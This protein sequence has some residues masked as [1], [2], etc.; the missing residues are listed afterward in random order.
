MLFNIKQ[1]AISFSALAISFALAGCDG[2]DGKGDDGNAESKKKSAGIPPK[3]SNNQKPAETSLAT[4]LK[5]KKIVVKDSDSPQR[6]MFVFEE[7][8]G[9]PMFAMA[10]ETPKGFR[11]RDFPQGAYE[12]DG[13]EVEMPDG[14]YL[15]FS[16][17]TP[18]AGDTI[19]VRESADADVPE[20]SDPSD[21]SEPSEPSEPGE[22]SEP[23]DKVDA[24]EPK[25]VATFIIDK[26]IGADESVKIIEP[27]KSQADQNRM[28]KS[29]HG[30]RQIGI[31]FQPGDLNP[32][33]E[34]P[35]AWGDVFL[36]EMGGQR[37][38]KFFLSPRLPGYEKLRAQLEAQLKAGN[39]IKKENRI[40]HYAINKSMIGKS[41]F[42]VEGKADSTVLMFECE[43]GW[44]GAGGLEDALKFMDKHQLKAIAVVMVRGDG[45][46]V[47][48]EELKKLTWKVGP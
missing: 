38:L 19:K 25:I 31:A 48:R 46:P 15:V 4:F 27:D 1:F 45:K 13:L 5:G 34:F 10:L 24:Q 17:K 43:L 40:C 16:S 42:D 11:K 18:K 28:L 36:K 3:A 7:I 21:P 29:I 33:G 37:G 26:I 6:A 9:L 30:L 22:P 39:E 20:P 32:N 44:N 47:T 12:V 2:G 41:I 23:L 35:A 14:Y 8:D